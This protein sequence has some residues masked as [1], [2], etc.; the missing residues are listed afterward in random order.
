MPA[1]DENKLY[2]LGYLISPLVAEEALGGEVN[3]VREAIEKEGGKI[4]SEGYPNMRYLAYSIFAKNGAGK[5][6]F[7]QAYFGHIKFEL[8]PEKALAL[9]LAL[10]KKEI[11]IRSLMILPDKEAP[12]TVRTAAQKIVKREMREA[13]EKKS[14][15]VAEEAEIEKGIEELLTEEVK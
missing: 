9:K 15:T 1:M 4:V 11:I 12:I 5:G 14:L 7:N 13:K 2:E 10:D 8:R 3:G 6:P